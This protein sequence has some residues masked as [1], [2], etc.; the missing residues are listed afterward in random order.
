MGKV[1]A[2]DDAKEVGKIESDYN[3]K[4]DASCKVPIIA[5]SGDGDKKFVMGLLSNGIDDRMLK[6]SNP[7]DLIRLS[8]FWVDYRFSADIL[9]QS[10]KNKGNSDNN[11]VLEADFTSL[12]SNKSEATAIVDVFENDG[13]SIVEEIKNNKLKV[14]DLQK[15]IH[16]LRGSSGTIRSAKLFKYLSEINDL[17]RNN[18]LP[19][20]NNFDKKIEELFKKEV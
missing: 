9:L 14:S 11:D 2:V 16:K 1:G 5:L 4:N 7:K 10:G 6:G 20:D 18:K 12:F 8:K 19:D 17:A 15:S 3:D 13:K